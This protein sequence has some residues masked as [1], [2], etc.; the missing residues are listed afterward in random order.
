MTTT[1]V[2]I[3]QDDPLLIFI[4]PSGSGKSS[5]IRDLHHRGVIAIT[6]TW[7]TRPRRDDERNGSIEHCFSS[8][9]RF[10]TMANSGG[11]LE[12][13]TMFG[14]PHRYGL[15]PVQRARG[16]AIAAVMLRAE[17]LSL[18]GR[19]YAKTLIYQIEDAPE[20]C[21]L[22]VIAR[23]DP[24]FGSR[25]LRHEDERRAG[26]RKAHRVFVNDATVDE[27]VDRIATAITSDVLQP[28]TAS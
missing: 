26:R 21:E 24:A 23:R 17:L 16:R 8:E 5:V 10:N 11:F 20:R 13:V 19:H 1:R 9:G 25:L 28:V 4:G 6:P 22:R 2:T 3:D 12:T 18:V 7:T 14:L 15:P 27:L